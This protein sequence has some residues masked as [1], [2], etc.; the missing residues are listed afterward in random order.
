MLS[1]DTPLR[2]VASCGVL[3]VYFPDSCWIPGFLV[4]SGCRYFWV[5]SD[6]GQSAWRYQFLAVGRRLV[7]LAS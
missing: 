2:G 3:P 4:A 5:T 7:I 6:L 1:G